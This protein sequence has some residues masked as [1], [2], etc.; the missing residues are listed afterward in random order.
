MSLFKPACLLALLALP[1]CG[2]LL[3]EGTADIAGIAAS[4]ISSGVTKNATAA[5]AIGLGVQSLASTGLK[6]VTRRLHRNEQ[7]AIAQAAGPLEQGGV[8]R[9]SISHTLPV[10]PDQQGDVA[11]SRVFGAGPIECKEVVF[12]IETTD[13]KQVQRAFYITNICNDGAAWRW[14][15]AEPATERWGGLQ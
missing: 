1:G 7:D 5:A 12:S 15:A 2:A 11:V 8:A 6:Y 13:K 4:G 14:A 9:W 3:T 10:E